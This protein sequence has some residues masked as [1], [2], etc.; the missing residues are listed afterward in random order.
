MTVPTA[1]RTELFVEIAEFYAHQ[2]PLLEQGDLE[3]FSGTFTADCSFGYYGA[4]QVQGREAV[5]GGMRANIP[6]Y[7]SSTI[8]HWFE[9]R[10]ITA[11]PDGTVEVTATCLVSVTAQD[12]TVFFEPSCS[13]TDL[14]VR[15]DDG[16][17]T[18]ARTIR[19]DLADPGTYFARLA[20]GHS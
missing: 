9:N 18:A 2:M 7:G 14:L 1:S 12:G 13:V 19:H 16:L 17:R 20:A 15:T 11:L 4:W 6:R 8:R 5:L 3:A 10:R